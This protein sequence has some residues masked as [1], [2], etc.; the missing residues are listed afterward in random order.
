MIP[1]NSE[2]PYEH[3]YEH[4]GI[5]TP[6]RESLLLSPSAL[7]QIGASPSSRRYNSIRK[8]NFEQD[9]EKMHPSVRRLSFLK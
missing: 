4:I 8:I 2:E 3:M 7:I 6:K 5:R 9:G 1:P